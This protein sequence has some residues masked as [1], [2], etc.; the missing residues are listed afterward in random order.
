MNAFLKTGERC[1]D[2]DCASTIV[3]LG[4]FFY[5]SLVC[6]E[7]GSLHDQCLDACYK[8]QDI[9]SE[10]R[11]RM[12]HVLKFNV[13]LQDLHDKQDFLDVFDNFLEAPYPAV[14][15]IGVNDLGQDVMVAMDAQGVNTL[16]HERSMEE[17]VCE[18]CDS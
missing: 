4:D 2:N 11:L 1:L 15:I 17:A 3:Q 16:R 13:Y 12:D 18:D 10:F 7:G 9:L 14:S 5:T 6:G 8:M